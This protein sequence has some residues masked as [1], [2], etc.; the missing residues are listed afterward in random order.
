MSSMGVCWRENVNNF[1]SP[2]SSSGDP[3]QV[4]FLWAWFLFCLVWGADFNAREQLGVYMS[5][6]GHYKV[7]GS[8]GA[9][10]DPESSCFTK[11]GCQF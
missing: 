8:N 9:C 2:T 7:L 1:H 6:V 4:T 11:R 10:G 5:G 3:S